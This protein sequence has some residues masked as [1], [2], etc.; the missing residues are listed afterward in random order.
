MVD[1]QDNS[2]GGQFH[3]WVLGMLISDF[4]ADTRNALFTL[5][6]E[7]Y[8][9]VVDHYYITINDQVNVHLSE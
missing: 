6:K 2:L 5:F 3:I 7:K 8:H 1:H 9:K 4:D